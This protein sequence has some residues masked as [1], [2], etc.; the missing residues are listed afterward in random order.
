M[1][2][3]GG[4]FEE[5]PVRSRRQTEANVCS[6]VCVRGTNFANMSVIKF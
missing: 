5:G 2:A 1:A 3:V 4:V 6:I